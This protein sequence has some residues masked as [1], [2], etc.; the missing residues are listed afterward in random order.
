LAQN[1]GII[2]NEFIAFLANLSLFVS[3]TLYLQS[4]FSHSNKTSRSH[5]YC[6]LASS[7]EIELRTV[8]DTPLMQSWKLAKWQLDHHLDILQ[9]GQDFLVFEP[10]AHQLQAHRQ[11]VELVWI[12]VYGTI[13]I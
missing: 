4:V 7:N 1:F 6:R 3:R 9:H 5:W 13:P 10:P 2:S 11:T 8:L 12:I